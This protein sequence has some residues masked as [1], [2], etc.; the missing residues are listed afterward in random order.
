MICLF[1]V[2]YN[3]TANDEAERQVRQ[4]FQDSIPDLG[5][6]NPI[7]LKQFVETGGVWLIDTQVGD[8]DSSEAYMKTISHKV[9]AELNNFVAKPDATNPN[10]F[11]L[12]KVVDGV[13]S[14][15]E[16]GPEDFDG[17]EAKWARI[18]LNNLI[19]CFIPVSSP[20]RGH[21]NNPYAILPVGLLKSSIKSTEIEDVNGRRQRQEFKKEDLVDDLAAF[22]DSFRVADKPIGFAGG[23]GGHGFD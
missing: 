23:E 13:E 9:G 10:K 21:D 16:M 17:T 5:V 11:K 20:I 6:A 7:L 22:L 18:P 1:I 12:M 4:K 14:K 8:I 2:K 19:E 15:I 3:G